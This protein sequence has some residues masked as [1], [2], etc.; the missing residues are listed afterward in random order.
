M[1]GWSSLYLEV[2]L[3]PHIWLVSQ[4]DHCFFHR[5]FKWQQSDTVGTL[6][7][8]WLLS[9][10]HQR[11]RIRPLL[12]EARGR[13]QT[14]RM[15]GCLCIFQGV[16]TVFPIVSFASQHHFALLWPSLVTNHTA[17]GWLK[18]CANDT[19]L[20]F[21]YATL[22]GQ[23]DVKQEKK[24]EKKKRILLHP[25][26]RYNESWQWA[27]DSLSKTIWEPVNDGSRKPQRLQCDKRRLPAQMPSLPP[28]Y[29]ALQVWMGDA[30]QHT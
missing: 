30:K 26:C 13:S 9:G 22:S 19:P 7:R 16:M 25:L 11:I 10:S 4:R 23:A 18:K 28:H 1:N 8:M 20:I 21:N 5:C 12:S 15:S 29:P 14:D 17:T 27:G 6:N 24:K 2:V 3:C